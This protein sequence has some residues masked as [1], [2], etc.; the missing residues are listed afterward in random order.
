MAADPTLWESRSWTT[1]ERR[2]G[3]ADGAYVFVDRDA[4]ERHIHDGGFLEWAEYVGNLYGTPL[5]DPPMGKDVVLVIEVQ[6]AAQV[7]ERVPEAIMILVVP[8]S[9][10]VQA[11][12]MRARGDDDEH[13]RR[14][15]DVAA[16]EE[17][18]GRRLAQHVVV[19]DTL[20]AAV[21]EVAGILA[22]HRRST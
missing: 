4:F 2:V 11:S 19:N 12:R 13:V 21:H 17:A 20:D 9:P 14:R 18:A 22:S 5:P 8:P 3:E 6:G 1:R 10:E 7:H 15:L 16:D